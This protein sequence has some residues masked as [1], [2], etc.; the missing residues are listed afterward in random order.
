MISRTNKTL[1]YD[2]TIQGIQLNEDDALILDGIRLIQTGLTDNYKTFITVQGRIKVKGYL[3]SNKYYTH[4]EAFYPDGRKGTFGYSNNSSDNLYYPMISIT[5]IDGNEIKYDYFYSNNKYTL[6]KI[7]Y[8]GDCV[9]DF[10]YT[11]IHN[12]IIKYSGG[13]KIIENNVLESISIKKG[14]ELIRKYS[15]NYIENNNQSLLKKISYEGSN[16]ESLNPITF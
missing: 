16:G 1:F 8:N 3:N 4:F 15:F 6:S 11:S 14:D 10:K 13:R 9:V 7:K 12:P 5:D 2:K